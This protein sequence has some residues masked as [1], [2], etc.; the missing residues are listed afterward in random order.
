MIKNVSDK[1]VQ[2]NAGLQALCSETVLGKIL[3]LNNSI[4][5]KGRLE[6]LATYLNS[7][8]FAIQDGILDEETKRALSRECEREPSFSQTL[9]KNYPNIY[10]VVKPYLAIELPLENKMRFFPP[11][12]GS[13][14]KKE[15]LIQSEEGNRFIKNLSL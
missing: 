11:V 12:F 6:I 1:D 2:L 13:P 3:Y 9:N 8:I 4:L 15:P 14:T 10:E 5:T 7:R